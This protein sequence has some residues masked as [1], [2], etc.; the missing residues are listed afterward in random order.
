MPDPGREQ[1]LQA[2]RRRLERM[3]WLLD[4]SIPLPGTSRRFGLDP[5][6][7]LIP[8]V[9]DVAGAMLS[10]WL[11]VEAARL[12]APRGVLARMAGN[13]LLETL[14]GAI[15]VIGDLFDF[16]WKANTRNRDLLTDYIDHETSPVTPVSHWFWIVLVLLLLA[17]GLLFYPQLAQGPA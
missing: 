8:G 4:D 10:L 11:V 17:M 14:V 13:V 15:P 12:G 3:A 7:G 5:L 16:I 1:Q 6:L 2:A 9:G